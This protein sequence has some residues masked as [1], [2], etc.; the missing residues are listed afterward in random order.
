[1][2]NKAYK[3]RTSLVEK[4]SLQQAIDISFAAAAL[5]QPASASDQ[6]SLVYHV[7]AL[8]TSSAASASDTTTLVYHAQSSAA[9]QESLKRPRQGQQLEME[10]SASSQKG[11][12]SSQ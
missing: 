7:P 5:D 12:R 4:D 10:S 1:M 11:A 2:I 8:E 3:E 9:A 6:T